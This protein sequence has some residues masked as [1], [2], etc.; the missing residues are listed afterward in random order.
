M[1]KF[2]AK[3]NRNIIS[4]RKKQ[5]REAI[6]KVYK[7]VIYAVTQGKFLLVNVHEIYCYTDE[8]VKLAAVNIFTNKDVGLARQITR[9]VVKDVFPEYDKIQK[10][11]L[12][13]SEAAT[14]ILKHAGPGQ[15][16]I[17]K[18]SDDSLRF[19]FNDHGPGIDI[20]YLPSMLFYKGF[21]T[22]T[23]LG[24]GFNLIYSIVD[25]MILS[26]SPNGTTVAFDII[27]E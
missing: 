13:V 19:I 17:K 22:K 5:Q 23:S 25:K 18:T 24:Y 20:E 7:D 9:Q 27:L 21:S 4:C 14:N 1:A 6:F 10:I 3:V 8:G 26:S 11:L 2:K 16:I 12:C 15:L